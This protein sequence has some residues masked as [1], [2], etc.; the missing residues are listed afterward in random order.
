[1]NE[2]ANQRIKQLI[3]EWTNKLTNELIKEFDRWIVPLIL[4]F[5]NEPTNE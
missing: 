1:M 2:L 5:I 4:S 3:N